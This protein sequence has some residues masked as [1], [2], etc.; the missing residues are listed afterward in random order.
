MSINKSSN[1]LNNI[2]SLSIASSFLNL[3][4]ISAKLLNDVI[5]QLMD[6]FILAQQIK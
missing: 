6:A 1:P 2:V 4:R 5:R 3:P